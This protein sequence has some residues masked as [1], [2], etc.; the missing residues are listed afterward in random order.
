MDRN[1]FQLDRAGRAAPILA[2]LALG[3]GAGCGRL[4]GPSSVAEPLVLNRQ[5]VLLLHDDRLV[6]DRQGVELVQAR[7]EKHPANPLL[8]IDRPWERQGI[9]N[10][11]A[12]LHD[13]EEGLYRMWYQILGRTE[14]GVTRSHCLYAESSDG[15]R[16]EK[17]ELGLVDFQGSKRNNILFL[18]PN[19]R[20]RGTP[21]YWVVKDYAAAD[22]GRRF[23]MMLNRWDF[24]GR[25][26]G[27]GYSP[28]GIHWE[29]TPY[30]NRLGGFDTHNLFFWDDRIGLFVG[31]FRTHVRGKRSIGRGT[32]PDAFHW[33]APVT[34]H[35]LDEQDPPAWQIYGPGIFKYSRARDV[36]VMYGEG[37][38]SET[39]IFRGQLGLSRDGIHW[40]RFREGY[41][42]DTSAGT[43]DA[44]SVRPVPAE[45][46][47]DGR[48][49][50]FYTG[51]DHSLH[52]REGTRG[53]GLATYQQGAFAGWRARSE[54][55]LTTRLLLAKDREP[56]LL[57][58]AEA[59]GGEIRAELLDARGQP[60]AGYTREECRP[61]TGNGHQQKV[62]WEGGES[63]AP[64][65]AQGAFSIRLYLQEATIYGLRV[66]PPRSVRALF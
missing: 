12:V 19:E 13:E 52:D 57:L 7:L 26:V 30:V 40:K 4:P 21:V 54:G 60:I 42:A 1:I 61:L 36:Y 8:V 62:A 51:S 25:G 44:G 32:S 3:I 9:L 43:W 17:P 5:Q 46:V 14:E 33:S 35:T 47:V 53:V 23:K 39:E 49:A 15:V 28:D 64:V 27:I 59:E 48:M 31:Y 66:V 20:P 6:R 65:V 55:T 2:L 29:F 18:D 45:A 41:F 22:T 16:W 37:Y 24:R 10:Y 56:G 38:E 50:V 34:V 11:V 58:N 63:L